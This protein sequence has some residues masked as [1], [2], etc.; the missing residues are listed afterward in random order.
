MF[1]FVHLCEFFLED[2]RVLQE[3][4]DQQILKP[5]QTYELQALGVA[6]GDV[7]AEHYGLEWVVVDDDLGRSRALRYG[8]GE[9]L[10]FPITMISKRVEVALRVRVTDLYKKA[11]AEVEDFRRRAGGGRGL[12]L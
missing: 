5:D 2:L 4:L 9:D 11:E 10:V 3:L 6:L 12:A 7:L 8:E 1:V